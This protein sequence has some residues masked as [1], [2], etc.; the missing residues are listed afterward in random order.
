MRNKYLKPFNVDLYN[1]LFDSSTPFQVVNGKNEPVNII[2]TEVTTNGES[3]NVLYQTVD[4]S[5][6]TVDRTGKHAKDPTSLDLYIK[7]KPPYKPFTDRGLKNIEKIKQI[8]DM[9]CDGELLKIELEIQGDT[10]GKGYVILK[11]HENPKKY[12]TSEFTAD[13]YN[14]IESF[15]KSLTSK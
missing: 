14:D 7:T 6:F 13:S 15:I 4:G 8:I 12:G 2:S 9:V 5:Y 1:E 11:V 10:A 3:G